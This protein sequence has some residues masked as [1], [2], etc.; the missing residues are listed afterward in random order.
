MIV[1]QDF[2][3]TPK[4]ANRPLHI[5]LPDHYYDSQD[6]YPV[7]Y[8][9]DGHNLFFDHDATYGKSWGFREFL[10][11]WHKDM[12]MVGIECGHEGQERLSEYLPYPA[13]GYFGQF[14]PKGEETMQ[15]LIHEIKPM[16]DA[17]Y[18]TIP[19]REHTGIGGSS[20][21]G[22]MA[23]YAGV[24]HNRWF[25]KAACVS[26]AMSFCMEPLME[27]LK[28]SSVSPNTRFYMSWGSKEARGAHAPLRGDRSSPT[29]HN[30][31]AVKEV[32][33]GYKTALKQECQVGGG[34]CEADWEKLVP[35]FM[36]FLWCE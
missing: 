10:D 5:Y 13:Q 11:G 28:N 8:F 36:Q 4:G 1:K 27:D 3:Y 23:L 19:F 30:H 34:H 25:S 14:D 7:M 2:I 20:M 21:G 29:Y 17:K 24:H 26:T 18:R 15:W 16:I 32:L 12:I 6:R 31:K 9:F 22:L 33:K 35:G